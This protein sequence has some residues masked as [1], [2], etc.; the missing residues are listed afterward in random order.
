[1]GEKS[2][3]FIS[4]FMNEESVDD[5]Q[6]FSGV[7]FLCWIFCSRS[8]ISIFY[9]MAGWESMWSANGGLQP[10]QFFDALKPLPAL[11]SLLQR[12]TESS[13]LATNANVLVPGCGR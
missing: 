10:G 2:L 13:F 11:V 12:N 1:M 3:I 7:K 8:E 4:R 5:D 9:G 6:R